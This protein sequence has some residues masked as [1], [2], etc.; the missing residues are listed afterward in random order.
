VARS[1]RRSGLEEYREKRDFRT[2]PE[3]SG[4]KAGRKG[5]RGGLRFVVQKHDASH[6][7]YDLRL[8]MDGVMRS[9]AVP[10]GPSMEP[11]VRRL[12]MEVEDHPLEYND[13]E[14]TIPQGEYGGGT[15]MLWDEGTYEPDEIGRGEDPRRAVLRGY[16]EGK[17]LIT[18]HGERLTGS[19][20][21]VRT[22]AEDGGPRSKWLLMKQA[23]VDSAP[24]GDITAEVTTSVRSGRTMEEIAAGEGG[25]RVWR[26]NRDRPKLSASRARSR[27]P[28]RPD[29]SGFSPM[30]AATGREVPSSEGWTYEPKYD[31]IRVLAF[32]TPDS[33]ALVTRNGN[34][35]A[36]Q[37][38]EVAAALEALAAD[39]G[40]P[41]VLDGELVALHGGEIAR[42]ERLQGRMHVRDGTRI[43]N[44]AEDSPAALVAFDLLLEGDEVL[45]GQPWSDRRPVLER[46]MGGRTGEHLRLGE[47]SPDHREMARRAEA[48][49]WEGVIAKRADSAYRPGK[50][51]PDWLKLKMENRQELVVGG[52]TEPRK[53]RSH[54]GA[55]LLGYYD[56]EGR[57]VY[58]GHTGT[59]F[60]RETLAEMYRRLKRLERKTPP[61]AE[62]PRTN[63][64]AHWVTPRVVVEVKFNE[65]TREGRLRQPVF[66][67]IREDKDPGEV[68]REPPAMGP[69]ALEKPTRKG[70]SS[71]RKKR[72]A[73]GGGSAGKA[74]TRTPS[75]RPA[76]GS[77]PPVVRKIRR[78]SERGGEGELKLGR[79]G[80]VG[81]TSLDKVFFPA[82]GHTKEDLL[83]YYA[84]LADHLLPSMKDRPLVLKRFPNGVEG[85]AFYQQAAP[86][87]VPPGVRVETLEI[88]GKKQRRLVGGNLATLLYTVQLG[89]IS[90]DP[91]HS[92][93]QSLDSAD[94]TVLDLDPGP[95]A[96]FRRVVQVA[97][98][99][100]EEM[101][102]L[103]LHGALKTSGSSGLHIYLPLPR[104]TPLDAATLV[105]QIVA[106]RV[107]QKHPKL[108]TVERMTRKRPRG[109]IYVDYLQ[110]ILGKTVAGVYAVRAKREPTVSTPL[111]WDELNDDLDLREFTVDTVPSRVAELG[112]LWAPAMSK[113]NRLKD[114]IP[115]RK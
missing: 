112:D 36:R 22:H 56:D 103:G 4:R 13:F 35:K 51:S 1:A 81:I 111:D 68:T 96:D 72:G 34:D 42:F 113:A 47:T 84:T 19:F 17:L 60:T 100:R 70:G 89:A 93:V 37:F 10:K 106:T 80:T 109:T 23:D 73:G 18:I 102:E 41:V 91:W 28:E 67:G 65:W 99:V 49:G 114:L 90:Y 107:A 27:K 66:L 115:V 77:G 98:H 53:S 55:L 82:T 87:N 5:S 7:H 2:S 92:R 45:V 76:A 101:D 32:A 29:P 57:L 79:G 71:G 95:G 43:R 9:W 6:L 26:S 25:K 83:V 62:R 39:L 86:D 8:E 38:P 104:R 61:F 30:L 69:E 50:R 75:G 15:V 31:G 105:A 88:E 110:N 52:W 64:R 40:S 11:N 54:L 16:E 94:Y 44:R 46:V 58:A 78:L 63:E 48:G 59:G 3:P 14:G 74:T 85:E 21:L 108:A 12:A 33:V 24:G 97:L 20:A